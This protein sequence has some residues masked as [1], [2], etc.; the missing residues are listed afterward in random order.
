[1]LRHFRSLADRTKM[2]TGFIF[3]GPEYFIKKLKSWIKDE[4]EG[5]KE[6]DT[7]IDLFVKLSAPTYKEKK[8]VCVK[9]GVIEPNKIRE[10]CSNSQNFRDL[11][12]EIDFYKKGI[13]G[14][15][16]WEWGEGFEDTTL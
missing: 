12:R 9:E 1:M 13:Q 10:I 15:N 14:R 16:Q 3:S 4:V 2:S 7:R 6:L 8:Y 11:F 5:M